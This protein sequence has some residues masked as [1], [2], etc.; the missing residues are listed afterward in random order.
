MLQFWME[1]HERYA[2]PFEEA[3]EIALALR[4][5]SRIDEDPDAPLALLCRRL[6]GRFVP[7]LVLVEPAGLDAETGQLAREFGDVVHAALAGKGQPGERLERFE[8]EFR[9]LEQQL[10]LLRRRVQIDLSEQE[11]GA[12]RYRPSEMKTPLGV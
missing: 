2:S 9:D 10:H 12:E 3:E 7:D 11:H 5:L 8:K 6:G 4:R 1:P